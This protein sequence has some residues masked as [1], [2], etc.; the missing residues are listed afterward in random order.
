[1]LFSSS[2]FIFMFLPATLLGFHITSKIGQRAE[3][4]WLAAAS[5]FFYGYWDSRYLFVLV[6][7]ILV[8][9]W[10]SLQIANAAEDERK[11]RAWVVAGVTANLLLLL[12]YKYFFPTLGFL[13]SI[14]LQS[15]GWVEVALP[16]GISF[17]TFTQIAYLVDLS[18]GAAQRQS[19]V[20]YVLFVTFFPHLIAGP[21]IHHAEMM[22]QFEARKRRGL[23]ADDMA[24]GMTWFIL[25]LSKK[26]LIADRF[27][28]GSDALYA[29]PSAFGLTATWIGVLCYAIQLYFDFS[30]YSDMAL[31]LGRMFSIKFPFNFNSP[32]KARN[33]IDFW[34]RWHITLTRWLTTYLYNPISLRISRR[35]MALGKKISKNANRTLPGFLELVA[36]PTLITFF[37]AG[38]WHGAGLQFMVFGLLHG[39]Y[40]T[41]N[42][43]WRVFAS[44]R[45]ILQRFIPWPIGMALTASA[46]L[47]GQVFFR[48]AG[49][50]DAVTV[51]QG[52]FHLHNGVG[53]AQGPTANLIPWTSGFLLN[54]VKAAGA[55]VFC[56]AIVWFLPNTQ[57]ILRQAPREG[58]HIPGILKSLC[59]TPNLGSA[60]VM[61]ALFTWCFALLDASKS[62]LYFQF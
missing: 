22:P 14:G 13:Q 55:L 11:S 4:V 5:L 59:W 47:V 51:L 23:Q 58:L 26:V 43:A 60:L 32:Y 6:G 29:H 10:F 30:G 46:V 35:R 34:A 53:F 24:L 27:G 15:P 57:E 41:I 9:F 37:L 1:M 48:A 8:N 12:W 52:L 25:G 39:V 18:Q 62:F 54:P 2:V 49:V 19:F 44:N 16:L 50:G 40:L 45:P 7:S 17:F 61:I 28:P 38:V 31:G 33:I 42:H 3:F 20:S 56:F 36:Q 21:I